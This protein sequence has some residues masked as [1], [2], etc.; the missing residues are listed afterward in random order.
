MFTAIAINAKDSN[1]TLPQ[2]VWH[3]HQLSHGS[4]SDSVTLVSILL[5]SVSC[6]SSSHRRFAFAS[7]LAMLSLLVLAFVLKDGIA[8]SRLQTLIMHNCEL[9]VVL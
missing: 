2:S 4:V 5:W 1:I 7:F 8:T 9:K 6:W 3:P